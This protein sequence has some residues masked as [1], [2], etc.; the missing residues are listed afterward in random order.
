MSRGYTLNLS[1]LLALK[2]PSKVNPFCQFTSDT[3]EVTSTTLQ[4]PDSKSPFHLL[5]LPRAK[6]TSFETF[7]QEYI[8]I[9]LEM[10]LVNVFP[11]TK[12]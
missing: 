11:R 3:L 10:L 1:A 7:S 2:F 8:S 5:S 6:S 4:L 12:S 9:H